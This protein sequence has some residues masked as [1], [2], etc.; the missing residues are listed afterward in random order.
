MRLPYSSILLLPA[1]LLFSC[2][3]YPDTFILFETKDGYHDLQA[4]ES[5]SFLTYRIEVPVLRNLFV[6]D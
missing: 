3:P 6:E 5:T 2:R 4:T 1:L